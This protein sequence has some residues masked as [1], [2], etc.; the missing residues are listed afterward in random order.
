MRRAIACLHWCEAMG[1]VF[2]HM[3]GTTNWENTCDTV[4]MG[5]WL[6]VQR[7]CHRD[8]SPFSK[9]HLNLL[10]PKK[11]YLHCSP[12]LLSLRDWGKTLTISGT[13]QQQS[14]GEDICFLLRCIGQRAREED[15]SEHQLKHLHIGPSASSQPASALV[16]W[17]DLPTVAPSVR[18]RLP[19]WLIPA[20]LTGFAAHRQGPRALC[21]ESI[22]LKGF[23]WS[24]WDYNGGISEEELSAS[25]T[26]TIYCIYIFQFVLVLPVDVTD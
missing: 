24:Q 18:V 15:S 9:W 1:L 17:L 23:Y 14:K 7:M 3:V 21:W 11:G 5:G 4:F 2:Q 16:L 10:V 22:S 13:R 19:I 12:P 8:T 6:Q 20:L 26:P 25:L